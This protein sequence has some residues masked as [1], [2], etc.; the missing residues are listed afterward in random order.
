MEDLPV[1]VFQGGHGEGP[2]ILGVLLRMEAQ[3][4]GVSMNYSVL[5]KLTPRHK[6]D[7]EMP[8]PLA[9]SRPTRFKSLDED[10]MKRLERLMSE[11]LDAPRR[12]EFGPGS[13]TFSAPLTGAN[14]VELDPNDQPKLRPDNLEPVFMRN[15]NAPSPPE[16]RPFRESAGEGKAGVHP[17]R[18]SALADEVYT[19]APPNAPRRYFGR[20]MERGRGGM[21]AGMGGE[22]APPAR[23]PPFAGRELKA[24]EGA[25]LTRISSAVL[26]RRKPAEKNSGTSSIEDMSVNEVSSWML[27][28]DIAANA[29]E[30]V[31]KVE[32]QTLLVERRSQDCF[33]YCNCPC[34]NALKGFRLQAKK[35]MNR[36]Q[37]SKKPTEKNE[38]ST[39][40]LQK[41]LELEGLQPLN[42]RKHESKADWSA[43]LDDKESAT[44]FDS[45]TD[46]DEYEQASGTLSE[47]EAKKLRKQIRDLK[48]Q[49]KVSEGDTKQAIKLEIAKLEALL[50]QSEGGEVFHNT[51]TGG[52]PVKF[53]V[54]AKQVIQGLDIGIQSMKAGGI[55]D[56]IFAPE[57]GYGSKGR[58][59]VDDEPEVLPGSYL[60]YNVELMA[61]SSQRIL[62]RCYD[63]TELTHLLA[64]KGSEKHPGGVSSTP[65]WETKSADRGERDVE[66]WQSQTGLVE[67][68]EERSIGGAVEMPLR[69]SVTRE[70]RPGWQRDGPE[71][72]SPQ[73]ISFKCCPVTRVVLY[74]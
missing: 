36:I 9:H 3:G 20:G 66:R 68:R 30:I 10:K 33:L 15:D 52:Y 58:K 53:I 12:E 7:R 72:S 43:V 4:L 62:P 40:S 18:L 26:Q 24:W 73:E 65:I 44:T 34:L 17:S 19:S 35:L 11:D 21:R 61:Q 29:I 23:P 54:G 67:H 64:G 45:K 8:E 2:E 14:A 42:A 74:S 55:A 16:R 31:K 47:K 13:R 25:I 50:A 51:R 48:R 41:S 69:G 28:L 6:L 27:S 39:K 5:V 32:Q 60:E 1:D 71:R 70:C 46:A 57:Y 37:E 49:K 38:I 56:F 63:N 59:P 22:E